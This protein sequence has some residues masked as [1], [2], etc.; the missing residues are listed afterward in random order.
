VTSAVTI[1]EDV[2]IKEETECEPRVRPIGD[3]KRR[4]SK[5]SPILGE[6]GVMP[7]SK[8]LDLLEKLLTRPRR[9]ALSKKDFQDVVNGTAIGQR[10]QKAVADMTRRSERVVA[11]ASEERVCVP[12]R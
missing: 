9:H 4:P 11:Q 12:L 3:V 5:P 1:D 10:R 2:I 8:T 7:V 6:T